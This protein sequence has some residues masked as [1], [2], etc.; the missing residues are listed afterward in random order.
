MHTVS[1]YYFTDTKGSITVFLELQICTMHLQK[2]KADRKCRPQGLILSFASMK[3]FQ[4]IFI[5]HIQ[6][7]HTVFKAFEGCNINVKIIQRVNNISE[8]ITGWHD[9]FSDT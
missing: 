4:Y 2:Q 9:I 8:S 3:V 7:T 1:N 5:Y 6:I